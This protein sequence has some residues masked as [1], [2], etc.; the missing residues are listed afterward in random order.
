MS[1]NTW[2]QIT[3]YFYAPG[4]FAQGFLLDRGTVTSVAVPGA[5]ETDA[6]GINNRGQ[7]AGWYVDSDYKIHG[8]LMKP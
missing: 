1:I 4:L 6:W 7:V 8:F 3:G 5:I 2:G